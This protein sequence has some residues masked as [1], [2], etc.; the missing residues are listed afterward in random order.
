MLA[1]LSRT[2]SW[3]GVARTA[4]YWPQ[5]SST[6]PSW[7]N[8]RPVFFERFRFPL[9]QHSR[10]MRLFSFHRSIVVEMRCSCKSRQSRM[11]RRSRRQNMVDFEFF[12]RLLHRV[13]QSRFGHVWPTFIFFVKSRSLARI[14][15]GSSN[16]F[17]ELE[18][19]TIIIIWKVKTKY[20]WLL[21]QHTLITSYNSIS[22]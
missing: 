6:C 10:T 1:A 7:K 15:H 22:Y 14:V 11:Q 8:G 19:C 16:C 4:T 5:P 12:R 18:S 9:R 2:A 21:Y 20:R 17:K 13:S 3:L